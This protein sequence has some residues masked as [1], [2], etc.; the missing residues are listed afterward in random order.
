MENKPETKLAVGVVYFAHGKESGPWGSKITQLAGIASAR[1]F[2][3]ES[4]D[5]AGMDDPEHRVAKLLTLCAPNLAN[6]ILVGSSMGAYVATVASA[7]LHP[8]GLFLLAP[9]FYIE[10][11]SQQE[12]APHAGLTSIVHGWQDDVVPVA[13][14]LKYAQRY[15]TE[16]HVCAGDHRLNDQLPFIAPIFADFLERTLHLAIL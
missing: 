8:R 11:Y 1:G 9:A 7:N 5:Y 3:V 13:N 10:R 6:L 15:H 2:A 4:P 12:P 16:L 14:S